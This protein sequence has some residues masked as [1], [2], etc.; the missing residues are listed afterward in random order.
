[1]IDLVQ[2]NTTAAIPFLYSSR[3]YGLLWNNPATGR[4]ELGSDTTRWTADGGGRV[5]YWVTAG[6][7][8]AQIIDAYPTVASGRTQDVT[9]ISRRGITAVTTSAQVGP[10]CSARR[11]GTSPSAPGNAPRSRSPCRRA[12]SPRRAAGRSRAYAAGHP[13]PLS[14]SPGL[15]SPPPHSG[16]FVYQPRPVHVGYLLVYFVGNPSADD[17]RIRM[18]LS[19]GNDPLRYRELNGGEPVLASGVG[20]RGLRD[21][22]VIRS[23][24]GDRFHLIATDLRTSGGDHDSG[25]SLWDRAERAGSKSIVVWDSTDLV[26]W[27]DERLVE[28]SPDNAGNTWAPKACYADELGTYVV[29]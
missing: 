12:R 22:F 17:E 8:P 27:T 19:H 10:P 20:T 23:P 3:G 9:L 11:R 16:A 6:D 21:P 7:T 14:R 18:A 2:L 4:V 13:W 5:D 26:N 24:D 25:E 15:P 29:F 1:M 28:V